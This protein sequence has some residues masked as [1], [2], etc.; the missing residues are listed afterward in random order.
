VLVYVNGIVITGNDGVRIK[1]LKKILHD[2]FHIKDLGVLRY[3]LGV[4]VDQSQ[5]LGSYSK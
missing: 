2:R 3:F 1:E 5:I 4:Q